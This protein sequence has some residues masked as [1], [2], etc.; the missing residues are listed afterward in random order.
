M[1]FFEA[2][3]ESGIPLVLATDNYA[4][5]LMTGDDF[6]LKQVLAMKQETQKPMII[7]WHKITEDN[8]ELVKR[9][10]RDFQTFCFDYDGVRAPE[11][12]KEMVARAQN[13][14]KT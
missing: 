12:L 6:V 5:G 3:K 11:G 10:F 1:D 14:R 2:V 13:R 4:D 8:K 7:L 9:T